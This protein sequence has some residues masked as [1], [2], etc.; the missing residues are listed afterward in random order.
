MTRITK[1]GLYL[2]MT[3]EAYFADPAPEPSLT[4]S[5]AKMLLTQSPAHA[6][7]AHPRLVTLAEENDED[8]EKYNKA[9]AIGNAAH[10]LMIGRGKL[11]AEAN[12]DKW[13][14]KEAKAFKAEANAAGKMPI[15][16]KHLAAAVEMVAA[17]R[18]QLTAAGLP[19]AFAEGHGEAVVCWQEDGLWFRTMIDFLT[20]DQLVIYDYKTSGL[21]VAPHDIG[22]KA[23][24][25]GWDIQ[26]A[27]H[28]RA[29]NAIDPAN[30]GRRRF[31]FIA[32]EQD[33]PYALTPVE[34]PESW[35]TLGR[36]KLAVAINIWRHCMETQ[37]WPAYPLRLIHPEYPAY[38]E[39]RWTERSA[40]MCD[41][42]LW[43]MDDPIELGRP[44]IEPLKINA[45][46]MG[47]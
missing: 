36:Q 25:D 2:D 38:L 37:T 32:Q 4:Q 19:D 14:T 44:R 5:I 13:T 21:S 15:L 22:R 40:S 30:A 42:G 35:L 29:L 6:R 47:G 41:A 16:S 28:D 45:D 8:E 24:E 17:G 20:P 27:M 9:K 3:S 10:A 31:R 11:I 46:M 18:A 43:S 7:I 12:F 39:S 34:L 23:A 33:K 1:P 26:A